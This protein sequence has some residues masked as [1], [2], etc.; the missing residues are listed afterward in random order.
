MLGLLFILGMVVSTKGQICSEEDS[1]FVTT[2]RNEA[3]GCYKFDSY[4][5]IE[6]IQYPTYISMDMMKGEF[7]VIIASTSIFYRKAGYVQYYVSYT[8]VEGEL[9][10]CDTNDTFVYRFE[11]IVDINDKGW[12]QCVNSVTHEIE[13]VEEGDMSLSC[14]C[15]YHEQYEESEDSEKYEQFGQI[16]Q[17]EQIEQS[18]SPDVPVPDPVGEDEYEYQGEDDD[19]SYTENASYTDNEIESLSDEYDDSTLSTLSTSSP[20]SSNEFSTSSTTDATGFYTSSPTSSPTPET[21]TGIE[22][23]SGENV[24]R[25]IGNIPTIT[26]GSKVNIVSGKLFFIFTLVAMIGYMV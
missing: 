16:Q 22:E 2:S 13:Q 23:G 11:N 4:Q 12:R 6:G 20:T 1:F 7:S 9:V 18:G 24:D 15:G 3:A 8:N 26:S 21:T 10:T 25:G 5:E 14:G 17:F 19:T